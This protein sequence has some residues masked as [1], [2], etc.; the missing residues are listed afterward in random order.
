MEYRPGADPAKLTVQ[1]YYRGFEPDGSPTPTVNMYLVTQMP[2]LVNMTLDEA[3]AASAHRD[4]PSMTCWASLK[5]PTALGS[6]ALGMPMS[7]CRGV[8]G[9]CVFVGGGSV[10]T[11]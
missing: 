2:D 10:P 1:S 8:V 9:L 7:R 11:C 4:D 3:R 5:L 6:A